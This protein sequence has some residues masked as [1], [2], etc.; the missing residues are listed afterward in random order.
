LS[1]IIGE[2]ASLASATDR[3]HDTVRDA[4][5][6]V[7]ILP[8]QRQLAYAEYG[9]PDGIPIIGC[10]GTPG[11][12]LMMRM[13]DSTAKAHGL[14]IIAP[15]RPGYGL[16]SKNRNAELMSW[17]EDIRVLVDKLR[18]DRF[19]TLGVSGGAP[20][21]LATAWA[22]PD[23]VRL[24]AVVSGLAPV[25]QDEVLDSLNPRR[26]AVMRRTR[27]GS[28]LLKVMLMLGGRGWRYAPSAM[29]H[30]IASLAPEAEQRVLADEGTRDAMLESFREAFRRGSDGVSADLNAFARPWGF[31][32]DEIRVPTLLWHGLADRIVPPGMGEYLKSRIPDCTATL[33]EEGGHYWVVKNIESVISALS[34]KLASA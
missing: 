6:G 3:G 14:R 16:S 26:A 8:D 27:G 25:D 31:A 30:K 29:M 23:R 10:H 1:G 22:M 15:D 20:Y 9:A 21:A 11:S 13:A 19:V 34:A 12:R 17:P 18:I 5:P 33:V 7:I 28:L 32:L 4:A 24:A 2:I